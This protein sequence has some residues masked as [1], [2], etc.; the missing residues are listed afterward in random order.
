MIS[1]GS[2]IGIRRSGAA[3]QDGEGN[4]PP[5]PTRT[6]ALRFSDRVENASMIDIDRDLDTVHVDGTDLG[7]PSFH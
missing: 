6:F 7:L 1:S 4:F 2:H 5:E 3:N